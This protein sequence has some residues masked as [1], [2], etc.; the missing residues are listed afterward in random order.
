MKR[1]K[2]TPSEQLLPIDQ[3]GEYRGMYPIFLYWGKQYYF[4]SKRDALRFIAISNQFFTKVMYKGRLIYIDVMNKYYKDWGYFEHDKPSMGSSQYDMERRCERALNDI[5]ECFNIMHSRSHWTNGSSIA[6]G[7]MFNIIKFLKES[8]DILCELNMKRNS[9]ME[10]YL[11]D[12]LSDDILILE[13]SIKCFG[14]EE[15][16]YLQK[17]SIHKPALPISLIEFNRKIAVA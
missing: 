17:P 5:Q 14:D 15:A 6:I 9:T 7:Q 10:L 2:I 1:I 12:K 4:G 16:K 8:V 3:L 13:N 11:L